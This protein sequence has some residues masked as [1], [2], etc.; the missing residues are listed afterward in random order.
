VKR[1]IRCSL[2]LLSACGLG[3]AQEKAQVDDPIL[4]SMRDELKRSMT[5]KLQ[6]LD[7]PYFIE[8]ELDDVKQFS[9]SASLGGLLASSEGHFR[10][11]RV[12]VRVGD[13]KFDNTDWVGSGYNFGPRYNISL[14]LEDS[15]A[16]LRQSF[17]LATDQAY[18]SAV[19]AIARKRSAL[20]NVS[21]SEEI[22]DF[23]P[24]KP[25]TLLESV[26]VE[27]PAPAAW[28]ER[29]RSLSGIFAGYPKL[30]ASGTEITIVNGAR[31]YRNTEGTEVRTGDEV[32]VV[33]IRAYAQAADGMTVRDSAVFET[34]DP[35]RLPS[36][37]EMTRATKE[38]AEE[39][40]ALAGAPVGENYSGPV[41]FE[42][43]AG[44]QVF[45]EVLGRNLSLSRKPVLEPGS[46]G[47]VSVSELEGRQGARILPD[48][49]SVVDDPTKKEFRGMPLFGSYEADDE[50]V[51]PGP[52]TIVENGTLKNFLMT[53]QPVRGFSGSNG[54]ARL[55]GQFGAKTAV[56]GNLFVT[57][58]ETSPVAD[59]KKK[60][61]EMCQQRQKPYGI[62]VRKMDFPSSATVDEARRIMGGA[63]QGNTKPNSLPL[64][65]YRVYPDGREE[66]IRGVRFR[67]LNARSLKDILAAG[68]DSNLFDYMENGA[69][70]ALMGVG[71]EFAEVSV[72]APSI[73]VD[74][75]EILKIE[76][77]L[78]KLPVVPPPTLSRLSPR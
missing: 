71:P 21:V 38:L 75:L 2:A 36:E 34:R 67:G 31:Y 55:A 42:G 74:D 68:D 5:L 18:K 29:M 47:S 59:L 65:V 48:F 49:I 3:L 7:S 14:P 64:L 1:L 17:W 23:A 72:V 10:V 20:K 73:L 8:Y 45:A 44:P 40:T 16:I 69:P 11:P 13:Y 30:K 70:F 62:L 77:E 78:P 60:L 46:P 61:I 54:H 41:L 25:I 9:A 4:R 33:R 50:G 22:P 19:E 51:K 39:V 12:H 43:A 76:D 28:V 32:A 24:A 37:A 63:G 26:T 66:P 57:A 58:T 52:L 15:Y 6:N 35:K 27:P 56:P 53:R